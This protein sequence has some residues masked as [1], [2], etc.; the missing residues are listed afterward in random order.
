M[1]ASKR[2][3]RSAP[4]AASAAVSPLW[5]FTLAKERN[6][7][8]RP[9]AIL[10]P[11]VVTSFHY[12]RGGFFESRLVALD[13]SSG[14]EVWSEVAAHVG[15]APV[16]ADGVLYWS[17]FGGEVM[18]FDAAGALIWTAAPTAR[19]IWAPMVHGDSLIVGEIH[20]GAEATWCLDRATGA[21]RW[22]FAHGGHTV[23][24]A[25]SGRRIFQ[26]SHA[27]VPFGAA[28]GAQGRCTLACL[29]ADTGT[30]MWTVSGRAHFHA[31]LALDD[32]LTATSDRGLH[33]F[34]AASGK[35]L[36]L[37]KLP[38][39]LA[40]GPHL[41][42][43]PSTGQLIIGRS[44]AMAGDSAIAAVVIEQQRGMFGGIRPV[45]RIAWSIAE[46]R[47][48]CGTP[49]RTDADGIAYLTDDATVVLMDPQTGDRLAERRLKSKPS[50][51]G[52][53]CADDGALFVAHGRHLFAIAGEEFG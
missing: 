32:R 25:A 21:T 16:V 6:V 48:I 20:G 49:V 50:S 43:S 51:L 18:S 44:G 42:P 27:P 40:G 28:M 47:G 39:D 38:P 45:A 33:I 24:I 52:G 9:P 41:M 53:I 30:P 10:G 22:Q 19:N 2:T 7:R 29:A 34:D 36:G 17:H 46:A 31:L 26:I 13:R 5:S 23:A 4:G 35:E 37:C 8:A 11:H 1:P 15:N 3:A 14:A 12:D